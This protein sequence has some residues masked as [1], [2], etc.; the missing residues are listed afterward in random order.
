MGRKRAKIKLAEA[1]KQTSILNAE[2][3]GKAIE[4]IA[5]A[6]A[7]QIR[8]VNQSIQKNFKGKAVY[9]KQLE[10]TA[11]ALKDNVKYVPERP[12]LVI[13]DTKGAFP[14]KDTQ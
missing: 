7:Q 6:T 8:V 4:T 12:T 2:G 5:N 9:Y 10:T 1:E 14:L 3:K 11:I 13:G